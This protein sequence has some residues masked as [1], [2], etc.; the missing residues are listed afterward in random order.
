LEHLAASLLMNFS[1]TAL[2]LIEFWVHFRLAIPE[3]SAQENPIWFIR[4][5][6][7]SPKMEENLKQFNFPSVAAPDF[8][9]FRCLFN[10]F[11]P[12][13]WHNHNQLPISEIPLLISF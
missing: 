2:P 1:S 9:H 6:K 5:A 13:R 4:C 3:L 12:I 11:R 7:E 10:L 8:P